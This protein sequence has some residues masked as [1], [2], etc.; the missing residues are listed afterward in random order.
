MSQDNDNQYRDG[1]CQ[2]L[3]LINTLI[4][5][6]SAKEA[7]A[8]SENKEN[9]AATTNSRKPTHKSQELRQLVK[10]IQKAKKTA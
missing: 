2:A 4:H 10:F 7:S 5:Q 9:Q 3:Q 6:L 1:L 8:S